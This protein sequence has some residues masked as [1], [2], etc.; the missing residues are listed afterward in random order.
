MAT[1]Q[2][3]GTEEL[4]HSGV[5]D[6]ETARRVLDRDLHGLHLLS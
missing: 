1:T 6:P 5:V 4:A 2:I 3:A